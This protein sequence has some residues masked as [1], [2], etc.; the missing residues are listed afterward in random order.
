MAK[1]LELASPENLFTHSGLFTCPDCQHNCSNFA[2]TCPACG[3]FFRSYA[4][5]IT[6]TPGNGWSLSVFWGI[7]LAW[8]IPTIIGVALIVVL[9]VMG[10]LTTAYFAPRTPP[11][12][13][14]SRP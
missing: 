10:L 7:M 2:E 14:S 11:E 9:F 12:A 4:R 13:P 8:I 5:V 6:V 1:S 3:R